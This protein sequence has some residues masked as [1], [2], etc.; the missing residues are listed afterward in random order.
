MPS[1][2]LQ[3]NR[4]K[5]CGEY[6]IDNK[7]RTSTSCARWLQL[8]SRSTFWWSRAKLPGP[9]V[10]QKIRVHAFCAHDI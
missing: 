4:K 8:F 1:L 3:Q 10:F 7:I 5:I 9:S 2:I 6:V